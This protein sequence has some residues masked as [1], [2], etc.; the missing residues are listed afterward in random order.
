MTPAPFRL[1]IVGI[2]GAGKTTVVRRLREQLGVEGDVA[3]LHAPAYHEGP[4]A[5]LG[6]LSRQLQAV[7]LATEALGLLGLKAAVMYLQMT[8]YG[9]VERAVVDAYEPRALVSDR[10][11][12]IDTLAYGPFYGRM[13]GAVVD[14]QRAEQ[15]LREQ[16]V[17]G[18]A[19]A[20]DATLAWHA[21]TEH[22]LG[23][24]SS[25]WELPQQVAAAFARPQDVVLA[26]FARRYR[27]TLPE[28]VV[29]L[30]V[31]PEQA[32][33]RSAMRTTRSS[34]V[35]ER[36]AVLEQLRAAYI[37]TLKAL[38]P[39]IAVHRVDASGLSVAQ[40]LGAVLE[41]LPARSSR[42]ALRLRSTGAEHRTQIV[43]DPLP[44]SAATI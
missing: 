21:R 7:S 40:T 37:A 38:A 20:L 3:T 16:L 12:I 29:L 34:M 22:R 9:A 39:R 14:V 23:Q 31:T 28:A 4:N 15:M 8:L 25:F 44:L 32:L 2:D 13:V 11:A 41:R 6:L 5:P 18:P 36:V 19:H 10:H 42:D 1:A 35:H 26:E 24:E 17:A 43:E 30:D 27:T 33:R